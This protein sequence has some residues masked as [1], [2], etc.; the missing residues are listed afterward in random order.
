VEAL[1]VEVIPQVI[2]LFLL[3]AWIILGL[4]D[5]VFHR[6]SRIDVHCGPW[7]SMFHLLLL[8]LAGMAILMGLL[9]ELN[10]PVLCLM[11]LC[12]ALHE[13]VAYIDVRFAHPRRDISPAE[14]RVH[15]FMTAV[16]VSAL[17]LVAVLHWD[18][19][20]N[21]V[22]LPSS[23]LTEPIRLKDTPLPPTQVIG[24]LVAVLVCDLVPYFEEFVRGMRARR[25]QPS[26]G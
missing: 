5:W 26:A 10:E 23:V 11:A 13:I 19:V 16:P 22:L 8:A 20:S 24:I 1:M 9:L 4:L 25:I 2:L 7:E 18:A 17:C 12:F 14:Q 3:P 15:D 21:L 6:R